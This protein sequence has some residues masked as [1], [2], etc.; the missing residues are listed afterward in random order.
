MAVSCGPSTVQHDWQRFV[1]GDN[2]RDLHVARAM[3]ETLAIFDFDGTLTRGDTLF[4]FL[5][6]VSG[7]AGFVAR[8]AKAL[9]ALTGFVLRLV[10]NE[11]AKEQLLA[12]FLR[13]MPESD[14]ARKASLFA[15]ERLPAM[16]RPAALRQLAWHRSK[17]HR[18]VLL[19]ASPTLYIEPWARAN[20]FDD[21]LAT[22]LAVDPQ[23]RMTGRLDGGNCQGVRKLRRLETHFGDLDGF[24]IYGYGD[25]PG[26]WHFLSRCNWL[27][28]RP[29]REPEDPSAGRN[30]VRDLIRLARPHQWLKN[31][32]VLVG[33][34]FGHA[35]NDMALVAAALL[36]TAAFS[37]AA[38]AVYVLNDFVDRESDRL[39]PR[40]RLRPLASG[41][42]TAGAALSLGA[43]LT[44]GAALLAVAA[45]STVAALIGAYAAL[46]VAYSLGLKNTVILDVFVIAAGFM[47]RILAGTLGIGIAPSQWLLFCSLFL[48]LFLGFT[49]RRA[50]SLALTNEG[51]QAHP[52]DVLYGSEMLDKLI[53]VCAACAIMSYGLYTVHPDTVRLHGTGGLI[54]TIPFVIYGMFRYLHLLHSERCGTDT[55][56]DLLRDRHLLASVFGWAVT[57]MLLIAY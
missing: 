33:L 19:T 2:A 27:R 39:H 44:I 46:N 13:G 34:I 6:F 26:D 7:R 22:R 56:D 18:C 30:R 53:S 1:T 40:K 45:G 42:V 31:A 52:S 17:G 55:S 36:A 47:L 35:W 4:P 25:S 9:P 48:T 8:L 50:E 23:G 5:R 43:A 16:M 20:G 12:A 15:T 32:F 14:L 49:K 3:R 10:P 29:F 51:G 37:L 24:D 21:V 57:T 41:R 38:S 28:Y 11:R 54:Y